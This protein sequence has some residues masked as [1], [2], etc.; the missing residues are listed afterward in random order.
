MFI[1]AIGK[2]FLNKYVLE[3]PKYKFSS[4]FKIQFQWIGKKR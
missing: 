2:E 1:K 3:V 4:A